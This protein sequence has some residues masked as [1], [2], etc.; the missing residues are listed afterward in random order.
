MNN[1]D[2]QHSICAVESSLKC[3]VPHTVVSRSTKVVRDPN[4]WFV[5]LVS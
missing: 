1:I 3:T 4:M 5:A 2:A